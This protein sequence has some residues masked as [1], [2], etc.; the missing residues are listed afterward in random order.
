MMKKLLIYVG[1]VS[2]ALLLGAMGGIQYVNEQLGLSSPKPLEVQEV[3]KSDQVV[4]QKVIASVDL[5]QKSE[6]TNTETPQNFFS[7][8]AMAGATSLEN[9]TRKGLS[10]LVGAIE[11][12]NGRS[13]ESETEE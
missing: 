5:V 2:V 4:N 6:A 11:G 12:L 8:S 3:K 10:S 9:L 13:Q 1:I 7:E